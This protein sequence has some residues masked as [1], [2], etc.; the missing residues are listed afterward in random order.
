M[1]HIT[2]KQA[3]KS[4]NRIIIC[5]WLQPADTADG[6]SSLETVAK[7]PQQLVYGGLPYLLDHTCIQYVKCIYNNIYIYIF[8]LLY[9]IVY[10]SILY[11][12]IV[13]YSILYYSIL[14]C[15]ILYYIVLCYIMLHY[16]ILKYLI[17]YIFNS[18]YIL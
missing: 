17:L 8:I 13:Y 6:F 14:Y 9:I 1:T 10:Y 16:I 3:G 4:S 7:L 11:Y 2:F 5:P 18:I 12:I 15:I